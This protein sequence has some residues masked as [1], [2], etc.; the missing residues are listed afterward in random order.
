M[1]LLVEVW[2]GAKRST[3]QMLHIPSGLTLVC[4][5]GKEYFMSHEELQFP[6][7]Y[8]LKWDFA[9]GNTSVNMIYATI[10][11]C[12]ISLSKRLLI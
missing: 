10:K 3:S 2:A 6:G 12:V 11:F 9:K 8:Y 1:V 4:E 5:K 7:Y